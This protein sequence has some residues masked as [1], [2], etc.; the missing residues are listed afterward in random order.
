MIETNPKQLE[1]HETLSVIETP[2]TDIKT[3]LGLK[4]LII[5]KYINALGDDELQVKYGVGR[6]TIYRYLK[7]QDAYKIRFKLIPFDFKHA[8]GSQWHEIFTEA[9]PAALD[10]IEKIRNGE[11]KAS[12]AEIG[13]LMG[14]A[15]DK[16]Q[17]LTGQATENVQYADMGVSLEEV[18]AQKE[19]LR[20]EL[21]FDPDDEEQVIDVDIISDSSEGE[22]GQK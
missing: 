12:L 17:L 8:I 22:G 7:S 9:V 13:T 5:D 11:A 3:Q 2:T 21:G 6:A 4:S 1:T 14:I 10:K 18:R 16:M 20:K 19:Q 15:T